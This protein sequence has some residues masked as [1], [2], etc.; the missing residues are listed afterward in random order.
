MNRCYQIFK[1]NDNQCHTLLFNVDLLYL[2]LILVRD[3]SFIHN[4]IHEK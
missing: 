3:I 1:Y 2:M 4:G